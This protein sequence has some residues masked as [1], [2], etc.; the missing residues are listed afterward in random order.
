M[1]RKKLFISY[2]W[3]DMLIANEI[4][5]YLSV[6]SEINLIRDVKCLDN[7]DNILD[8]MR[9]IK[10]S[11]YAFVLLSDS[12]IQSNNCMFELIELSKSVNFVKST[13]FFLIGD[14]SIYKSEDRIKY[15]KYW[16]NKYNNIKEE[17]KVIPPEDMPSLPED[18]KFVKIVCLELD[19][20]LSKVAKIKNIN[21]NDLKNESYRSIDFF[22]NKNNQNFNNSLLF[23]DRSIIEKHKFYY[24]YAKNML[25]NWQFQAAVDIYKKMIDIESD[26]DVIRCE[27][28]KCLLY[29][30]REIERKVTI[31]EL[32][33][34]INYF[35]SITP[36]DE[37]LYIFKSFVEYDRGDFIEAIKWVVKAI[38]TN[39][40]F[41]LAY[42]QLGYYCN[43]I[44]DIKNA[45]LMYADAIRMCPDNFIALNNAGYNL[46]INHE[47]NKS[48]D[49]FR[50]S[51]NIKPTMLGYINIGDACRYVGLVN[52]AIYYHKIAEKTLH[53]SRKINDFFYSGQWVM[54]FF[55]IKKD[56]DE[57][58]K[59]EI[60][61]RDL[62]SKMCFLRIS[63]VLD[64][65]FLGIEKFAVKHSEEIKNHCQWE[66]FRGYLENQID[67]ISSNKL[68]CNKKIIILSKMFF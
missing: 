2:S 45:T 8:F 67:F 56:D 46:K 34:K 30:A 11:D 44:G 28:E 65:F 1:Q 41:A 57:T 26:N 5:S 53:M 32:N 47:F 33:I 62:S 42:I 20:I 3:D 61:L 50:Q 39:Q 31:D 48:I 43:K 27:Y 36:N 16:E 66:E 55:A 25:L 37:I 4:E 68:L 52:N 51:I 17:S 40:S 15:I 29:K 24:L 22:L 54:N 59:K 6:F 60:T 35:L 9:Q 38:K 21:Y 63:Y 14:C 19:F 7:G 10:I 49:L 12:Y 58:I 64:Y 13:L 23:E 18:L